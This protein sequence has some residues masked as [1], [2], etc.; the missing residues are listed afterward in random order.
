M[1]QSPYELSESTDGVLIGLGIPFAMFGFSVDL[2]VESLSEDEIGQ[3]RR[4]D[5]NKFDRFSTYFYSEKAAKWS[6]ILVLTCITAPLTLL[7]PQKT[8]DD[9]GTILTMYAESI[10]FAT[11]LPSLSKGVFRRMRPFVYNP[12]VALEK[13]M[14]ANAQ[15]SFFSGHTS[16]A[17]TSMIFLSTVH[18]KYYP[19]SDWKPF[20]WGGAILLASTVGYLRI[21]AGSHF[22]SDVI[23]GALVGSAVG[24]LIPR[25]H[26]TDMSNT[27]LH[28]NQAQ[29][30]R[31]IFSVRF[32][33]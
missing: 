28:I 15:K 32:A 19:D 23:V 16:V 25:I 9:A 20:I 18:S 14:S 17:F 3:I 11:S 8:Q 22:P 1:A 5:V 30:T 24:Y 4:E 10:L 29:S 13:K 26:E 31:P 27:I 12:D 6:D 33:F 21:V 2:S 7:I